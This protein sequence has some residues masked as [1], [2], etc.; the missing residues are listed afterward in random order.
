MQGF[1]ENIERA[2]CEECRLRKHT[3]AEVRHDMGQGPCIE[4]LYVGIHFFCEVSATGASGQRIF[5]ST[6][7]FSDPWR[8][9]A[10]SRKGCREDFGELRRNFRNW[11][12]RLAFFDPQTLR[13]GTRTPYRIAVATLLGCGEVASWLA[14]ALDS[15]APQEEGQVQP[16]EL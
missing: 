16:F 1:V 13:A 7:S 9:S 8:F 15:P 14:P 6:T 11:S 12:G 4:S 2:P 10:H 5:C 3:T